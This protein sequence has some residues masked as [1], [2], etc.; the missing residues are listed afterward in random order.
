MR[1]KIQRSPSTV[2]NF[3][4]LTRHAW[5]PKSREFSKKHGTES[6]LIACRVKGSNGR[7]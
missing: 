4:G 5:S 6:A 7:V 2:K 3:E 1:S